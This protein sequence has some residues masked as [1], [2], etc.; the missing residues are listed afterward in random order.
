MLQFS[1]TP[2]W[3]DGD[4]PYNEEIKKLFFKLFQNGELYY[5]DYQSAR[6]VE[7]IIRLLIGGKR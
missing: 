7:T 3:S 6:G 4:R 2:N 1:I 5:S